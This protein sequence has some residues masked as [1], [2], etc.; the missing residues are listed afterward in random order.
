[1]KKEK[2]QIDYRIASSAVMLLASLTTFTIIWLAMSYLFFRSTQ[3]QYI[4][5]NIVLYASGFFTF[6][7]FVTPDLSL[8]IMSFIWKKIEDI[9]V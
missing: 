7:S 6:L 2:I 1:M 3:E 4:H 9:L 5:F 8:R